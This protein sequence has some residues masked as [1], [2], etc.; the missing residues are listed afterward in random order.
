M[1]PWEITLTA[2]KIAQRFA[3]EWL[4]QM[5][6]DTERYAQSVEE[7]DEEMQVLAGR[8]VAVLTRLEELEEELLK[9]CVRKMEARDGGEELLDV[10]AFVM[11]GVPGEEIKAWQANSYNTTDQTIK[12]AEA[13]D[14]AALFDEQV[15]N[16]RA[17]S[18]LAM[19][20]HELEGPGLRKNGVKLP[21]MNVDFLSEEEWDMLLGPKG[22]EKTVPS[23]AAKEEDA[24]PS[25]NATST[26]MKDAPPRPSLHPLTI[27]AI[28]EGLKLRAQNVSTSPLRL[29]DAQTEWFE[30]QY[31]AVKFADRFLEKYTKVSSATKA[32]K[33]Q[34]TWTEEELQTIGGRIV[35][36]LMRL[37][38]LEWE[39]NHRISTSS[40]EIPT[41]EWKTT[42]GLHPDNVEQLCPRTLD[43]AILEENDFARRRAERM[44]ALF[45][46][47]VEGPA[48]KASGNEV[49]GGSEVDFIDDVPEILE[50]MMP[51]LKKEQ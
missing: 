11:L 4:Q 28:E 32:N 50:L 20:L 45:L 23:V 6:L 19:F 22:S 18:L 1:E 15:R 2:G 30:V 37:D 25:K 36:V 46:L 7:I 31:T 39:W 5:Q 9:R 13:I 43:L 29:I 10:D 40:L 24:A 47:N 16:N 21:C 14:A 38:D 26:N 44:L 42:L 8:T 49:P 48:M 12:A 41:N 34:H 27:D 51:K 17:R 33:E 35:G 3:E